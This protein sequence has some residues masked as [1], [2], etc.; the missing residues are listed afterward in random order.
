[1]LVRKRSFPVSF[2]GDLFQSALDSSQ[3]G[4]LMIAPICRFVGQALRQQK[5]YKKA[6]AGKV[7]QKSASQRERSENAR[8]QTG[9]QDLFSMKPGE[10]AFS[11]ERLT[12]SFCWCSQGLFPKRDSKGVLWRALAYFCLVAKV[13]ACPGTRGKL[14]PAE[15]LN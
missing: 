6:F 4:R 7:P 14:A 5:L 10:W 11:L 15:R 3:K 12:D 9:Q 8:R 13:S 2:G 1:M